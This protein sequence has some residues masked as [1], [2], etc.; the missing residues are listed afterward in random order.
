MGYT[1]YWK[2]ASA[3]MVSAERL[4]KIREVFTAVADRYGMTVG[5]G[6]NELRVEGGYESFLLRPGVAVQFG[7]CKTAGLPYT[8]PLVTALVW[9]MMDHPDMTVSHDGEPEEL[10]MLV[11]PEVFEALSGAPADEKTFDAICSRLLGPDPD[12]EDVEV[13]GGAAGDDS[14]ESDVE[15]PTPLLPECR[16]APPAKAD[17]NA[18]GT[19][20]ETP[21][22]AAGETE[23]RS[24]DKTGATKRKSSD[25]AAGAA[26]RKQPLSPP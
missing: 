6:E 15:P 20:S 17:G 24:D 2:A 11:V 12:E 25:S 1:V 19:E 8:R 7:F 18:G 23:V 4:Q 26:K 5:G 16:T 14:D 9:L 10:M 21:P 22:A 13:R 3:P